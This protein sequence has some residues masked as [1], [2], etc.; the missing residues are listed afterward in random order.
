MTKPALVS[1]TAENELR[2]FLRG[3]EQH[4]LR[5]LLWGGA[6]SWQGRRGQRGQRELFKAVTSVTAGSACESLTPNPTLHELRV[7]A[8]LFS[9]NP[10]RQPSRQCVLVVGTATRS[11][12][13]AGVG[14]D[15]ADP[16][17][18]DWDWGAYPFLKVCP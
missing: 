4:S 17:R 3:F 2:E 10:I 7:A 8:L 18:T 15:R 13:G 14:T 16:A 9:T 12:C 1:S 5:A 11:S 6:N